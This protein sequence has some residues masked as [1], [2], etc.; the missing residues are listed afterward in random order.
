MA[1]ESG[2]IVLTGM[3]FHAHHGALDEEARLGARFTVDLELELT[4]TEEDRLEATVDYSRVY[5]LVRELVTGSRHKLIES[6]AAAIA[7][8]VLEEEPLARTAT[9]RVHKPH[10]PI[11]G[12][13]RDVY[14]EV[15]RERH[16]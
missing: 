5:G 6:L 16:G 12:V 9:A 10:A 14:V 3:E 13:V 8:E 7:R 1:D 11:P 15:R 4:V 2:R